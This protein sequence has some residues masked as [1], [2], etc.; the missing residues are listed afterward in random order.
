MFL[1]WRHKYVSEGC[2]DLGHH[3][4]FGVCANLQAGPDLHGG[5]DLNRELALAWLLALYGGNPFLSWRPVTRSF[6]VFFDLRLNKQLSIQSKHRWLETP[7]RSLCT[8][9]KYHN[10]C[11]VVANYF[12]ARLSV[13][14]PL[15]I[16]IYVLKEST[17]S[18][19]QEQVNS[20]SYMILSI[21]DKILFTR[22][23]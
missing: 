7:S 15:H 20:P 19:A 1:K 10:V 12:C 2:W 4:W 6:D 16:Y 9:M 11:I 17:L 13:I 14:L 18:W 3:T 23:R 5:T 21:W 22:V 8:V